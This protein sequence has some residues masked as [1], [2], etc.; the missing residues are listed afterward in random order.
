MM[1]AI[2]P[3]QVVMRCAAALRSGAPAVR[4][5]LE[6]RGILP[7]RVRARNRLAH[8]PRTG[9]IIRS[10][11]AIARSSPD[12]TMQDF[13]Q[14]G[15]FYLGKQYDLAARKPLD[16]LLL[17]DAKDLTTHAV[18]V[19]MTGSGKTGL[20]LAL[21]EEA[22]IDGVPAIAI[23][24]KG[25]LGNL[26]LTF[27]D[28]KPADFR[29][30]LDTAEAT[31]KDI[32]LDELA[33]Q[34][35]KTWREGL[36]AWG[37]DGTRIKRFRDAVDVA[38]YTPG[39]NT[40]IPLAV[41]RSFA[42]PRKELLDD[43]DALRERINGSVSGLL[44]LVGISADPLKSRE[45]ILLATLLERAWRDG[46]DLDLATLIRDVQQPSIERVGLVDI[47]TFFPSKARF[48][49]AMQLNN[50]LASPGFA[51]WLEGEPLDVQRL[52][53]LP[54]GK[55]RL[56]I[57]SIAHLSDSERMFFVTI[58][59]G[60]MLAWMRSQA[61]TS[62]LRAVLYM[63]EVAGYFPPSANPPSKPPMLTLLKQARA[64]G[65]GV[66]L[67]TQN[68]VDLDYKG[69]SNA[70]TWF[71]G[72]LQTERD[73][74]RV[75]EGL[76]GASAAA[77]HSFDRAR[78][79]AALAALGNRVFLMNNVHEDAPVVFQTRWTLSYLAGPLGREQIATLMRDR[80]AAEAPATKAKSKPAISSAAAD[81][82][83]PR[84]LLPSEVHECFLLDREL[85]GSEKPIAYA[86]AILG[87]AKVR[88]AQAKSGVDQTREVM[89][90]AEVQGSADA[91]SWD[92]AHDAD[93]LETEAA[94]VEN[95]RF[96]PLPKSLAQ[97]KAFKALASSLQNHLYQSQKLTLWQSSAAKAI[98]RAGE[99]E[100]DF[101]T[102][103]AQESKEA[104]DA[105]I[106]KLREKYAPKAAAL[107]ERL[108]KA[109][110]AVQKK[111]ADSSHQVMTTAVSLGTTLLGALLGRKLTSA[112]NLN[113]T[114]SS[115]RSAGRI[116]QKRDGVALAED[117]AAAVDAKIKALDDE[118]ADE[119]RQLRDT[120]AA[121]HLQLTELI[122]QPKK[123][124]ITVT[125]VLLAWKPT[126]ATS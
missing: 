111:E 120:F 58:L 20:C 38:I 86:P 122:V 119:T 42:A 123:S 80:K 69:L 84:P 56:S 124:D 115:I 43:A 37:E 85:S 49:L 50:V 24:P 78:M 98:S 4:Q 83:G 112:A 54:N 103:I 13:E 9:D 113:Q 19:G 21:L 44:A 29:P 72:R 89:L 46:R 79:E 104:R 31:R 87:K 26:L 62:S 93:D 33:E 107:A 64:F 70:G 23:D 99:S 102:R 15:V 3:E 74:A 116:L 39:S 61:G 18:C 1:L 63:D 82:G 55:P 32:S 51:A 68:P 48:E 101:R 94:P 41:L 11:T 60:E 76:E 109:Q 126:P 57:V 108:R 2:A 117:D 110:Q 30:W 7:A 125:D 105:A 27:P 65:L 100:A 45:H 59:L 22:A 97:A 16:H 106:D 114:A 81:G 88:F 5:S 28:G 95:V 77:G 12:T 47:D 118:L 14:L 91:P 6:K 121:E 73:K 66:V 53:Y 92:A 25:D 90:L 52:L 34:T 75:M 36:A 71:L 67:A 10:P 8:S 17:Y 96:A 35:A 40:G